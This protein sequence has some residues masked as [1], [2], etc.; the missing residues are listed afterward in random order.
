MFV[1]PHFKWLKWFYFYTVAMN[2]L[3]MKLRKQFQSKNE[4][5]ETFP[6][7]KYFRMSL[8]KHTPNNIY[9]LKY[10]KYIPWKLDISF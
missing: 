8:T 4:I 7:I 1:M 5:K 6:I 2:E 10:T 3:K 9:T